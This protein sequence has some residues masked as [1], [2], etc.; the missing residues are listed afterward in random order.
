M[1]PPLV[2]C[3]KRASMVDVLRGLVSLFVVLAAQ[4]D[5]SRR[6]CRR[7]ART[8]DITPY[9]SASTIK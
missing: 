8:Y 5:F 7:G 9:V 4:G 1:R 2:V 3:L 6:R